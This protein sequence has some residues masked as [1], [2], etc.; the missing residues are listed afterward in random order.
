[1]VKMLLYVW[2]C[3]NILNLNLCIESYDLMP[4]ILPSPLHKSQSMLCADD[5]TSYLCIIMIL[6]FFLITPVYFGSIFSVF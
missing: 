1:M 4:I 3:P 2:M 5:L 6:Q